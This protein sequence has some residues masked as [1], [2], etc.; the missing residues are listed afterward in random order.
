VT[1][2]RQFSLL[3][4]TSGLADDSREPDERAAEQ[5]LRD[6]RGRMKAARATIS[7]A[8]QYGGGAPAGLGEGSSLLRAL[9][10][11]GGAVAARGSLPLF[12]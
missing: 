8:P 4:I 1:P 5:R 10:D 3:E 2:T 12:G 6:P 11:Y 7:T 9:P